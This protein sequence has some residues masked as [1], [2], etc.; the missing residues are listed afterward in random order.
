MVVLEPTIFWEAKKD[1]KRRVT[2]KEELTM[3]EKNQIWKVVKRHDDR[4]V[5]GVKWI[6]RTKLNAYGSINKHKTRVVVNG[7]AQIFGIDFSDTFILVA[8]L[9]T[10][11]LLLAIAAKN[12]LN[13]YQLDV[14]FAFLRRKFMLRNLKDLQ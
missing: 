13:V 1:P 2:M 9:E 6:F 8:R 4:K 3:I 14:K 10:T 12:G 5:I 11:R 7:Y